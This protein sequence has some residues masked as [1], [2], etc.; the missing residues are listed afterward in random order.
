[1]PPKDVQEGIKDVNSVQKLTL[2]LEYRKAQKK[3]DEGSRKLSDFPSWMITSKSYNISDYD[4]E[5]RRYRDS[6]NIDLLIEDLQWFR[7]ELLTKVDREQAIDFKSKLKTTRL[8]DGQGTV[9]IGM[10]SVSYT[11]LT[12][13]TICSV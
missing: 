8:K 5:K 13:P 3:F 9:R 2:M 12:L 10:N 6:K 1:M 11:H 4:K 7:D